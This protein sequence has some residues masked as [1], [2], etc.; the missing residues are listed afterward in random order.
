M[1]ILLYA[2]WSFRFVAVNFFYFS[3]F[4]FFV[5]FKFISIHSHTPKQWKKW[6]LT[7]IKNLRQHICVFFLL[8]NPPLILHLNTSLLNLNTASFDDDDDDDNHMII[9]IIVMII[10]LLVVQLLS[11]LLLLLLSL[12]PSSSS[13][14]CVSECFLT[15]VWLFLFFFYIQFVSLGKPFTRSRPSNRQAVLLLLSFIFLFCQLSLNP[16]SFFIRFLLRSV[17]VRRVRSNKIKWYYLATEYASKIVT[18]IF[19]RVI[20]RRGQIKKELFLVGSVWE[21]ICVNTDISIKWQ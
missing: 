17:A 4:L 5:C 18:N 8:Y 12:L 9:I 20:K 10:I 11:L 6:K 1:F 19:A 13:F 16:F 7:K 14:F 15:G 2:V 21:N 3:Q